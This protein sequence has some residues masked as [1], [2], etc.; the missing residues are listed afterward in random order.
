MDNIS[1]GVS[2]VYLDPWLDGG[3][4]SISISQCAPHGV[5][6]GVA[7]HRCYNEYLFGGGDDAHCFYEVNE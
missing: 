3:V 4:V 2:G 5:S 1:C 7:E 6:A